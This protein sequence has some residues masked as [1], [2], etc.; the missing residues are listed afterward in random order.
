MSLSSNIRIRISLVTERFKT[1]SISIMAHPSSWHLQP[2]RHW[3][4]FFC[5]MSSRV[6]SYGAQFEHISMASCWMSL[7]TA[8]VLSWYLLYSFFQ[9]FLEK[10]MYVLSGRLYLLLSTISMKSLSNFPFKGVF[11]YIC[12][13]WLCT[14]HICLFSKPS[15]WTNKLPFDVIRLWM[16]INLC[17]QY[18]WYP[19]FC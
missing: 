11:T 3:W 10:Y 2:A 18:E 8:A 13:S 9:A 16:I 6:S 12:L 5:V 14:P 17:F 7:I 15:K 1:L 4:R 19:L